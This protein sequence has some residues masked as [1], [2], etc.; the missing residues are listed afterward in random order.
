[1]LHELANRQMKK[2]RKFEEKENNNINNVMKQV[3]YLC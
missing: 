1:M 3:K 2:K